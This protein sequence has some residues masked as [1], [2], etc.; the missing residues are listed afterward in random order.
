MRAPA[1]GAQPF[2][3]QELEAWSHV[4]RQPAPPE[5]EPLDRD[6]VDAAIGFAQHMN[7][8]GV[9]FFFSKYLASYEPLPDTG[10]ELLQL[11]GKRTSVFT[12]LRALAQRFGAASDR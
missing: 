2:R 6:Y 12:R 1:G 8:G 7:A 3:E 11:Y 5:H 4:G 9:V 10:P